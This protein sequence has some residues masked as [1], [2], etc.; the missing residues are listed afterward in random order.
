MEKVIY[1]SATSNT[2]ETRF[3]YNS[4]GQ[5]KK[6]RSMAADGHEL[7]Y[8]KTNL[9]TP[10][11]NL[12][13]VPR[14]SQTKNWV[15]DFNSGA[16]IVVNNS[17]TENVTIPVVGGSG[18]KIE[19]SMTG[20]PNSSVSK[21][22]VGA[23]GWMESLPIRSEDWAD[24]AVKRWTQ[25]EWTQDDTS[26]TYIVNPRTTKTKVGDS[27]NT[28]RTEI[29]Y[30][31]TGN[32]SPYGLVKE[33]RLYNDTT[34]ALQKKSII[35]YKDDTAYLS[36]RLIGLPSQSELYDG[37]NALMSKVTYGYDE[38]NF[39]FE[40]EQNIT[41][42]KHDTTNYGTGFVTGRGNLTS[43]HAHDVSGATSAVTSK[44][45]YDIAGSSVCRNRR[46]KQEDKDKLY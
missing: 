41:P 25:T 19:V 38:E 30:W 16:D 13:D 29:D 7:N 15:E 6:V 22:Y 39:T 26:K 24:S 21:T 35:N 44:T 42:I 40:T 23:S 43:T 34:N 45:R 33:V 27:A 46:E 18:T 4:F 3:E 36:R 20:H 28:K 10:G 12:T 5:V 11:T 37:S 8:V 14:L 31:N 32:L 2:G 9:E 1:G 17:I